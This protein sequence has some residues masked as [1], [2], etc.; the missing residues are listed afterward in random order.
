MQL[1]WKE[2]CLPR[3]NNNLLLLF[4]LVNNRE[5]ILFLEKKNYRK[6]QCSAMLSVDRV[7]VNLMRDALWPDGRT[8]CVRR[9]V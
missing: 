6:Q 8:T 1:M 9:P 4:I 2:L 3:I 5:T 7:L